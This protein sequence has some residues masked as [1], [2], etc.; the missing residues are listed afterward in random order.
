MRRLLPLLLLH[1]LA[2]TAAGKPGQTYLYTYFDKNGNTIINNLPPSYV[3]GQG[4][5]L[6]RVGVGQIRLAITSTQ[7]AKVL[8]SPELLTLVD[9]IASEEGVDPFLARAVIQAESAFYTRARSR[10]GALGLMQLMPQTAER[11][12]VLDPFDPRQNI[13]GGVKYLRWLMN[14]FQGDLP[15]VI[16]AYNAGEANVI[17]YK[18]IPP[19]A[20]TRAYV[21]RVMNLFTKRLVQAD[22]RAAGSMELLKKGRG[23]FQVEE[24]ALP[25]AQ[26]RPAEPPRGNTRIYHWVDASGRTQISDQPPPKGTPGVKLSD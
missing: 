14:A 12:G 23:G 24:K 8:K 19:F 11:F 9:T 18:G 1:S 4:L 20:E 5:T 16:A 13:T 2:A 21:P 17:K 25:E 26:P 6:K 22:P 10:A 7:M 3:K 15:R